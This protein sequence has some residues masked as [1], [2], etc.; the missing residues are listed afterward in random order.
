[1]KYHNKVINKREIKIDTTRGMIDI[2]IIV[3]K[4][5]PMEN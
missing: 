1:L 4:K 2:N 5:K 3:L